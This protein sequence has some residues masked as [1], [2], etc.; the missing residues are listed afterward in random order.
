MPLNLPVSPKYSMLQALGLQTTTQHH[1]ETRRMKDVSI[2]DIK[3]VKQIS[4][5]ATLFN[6]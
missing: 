3:K 4:Y 1:C 2:Q 5:G 6:R